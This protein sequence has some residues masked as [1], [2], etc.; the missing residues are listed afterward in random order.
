MKKLIILL[1]LV[2]AIPVVAQEPEAK[3]QWVLDDTCKIALQAFHQRYQEDYL[4][5]IKMIRATEM[6]I[7][8]DMP[9]EASFNEQLQAFVIPKEKNDVKKN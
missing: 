8:P 7:H 4:E 9:A 1:I 2:M 6:K 3:T 5:L